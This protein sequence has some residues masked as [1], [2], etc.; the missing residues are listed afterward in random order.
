[1]TQAIL[2]TGGWSEVKVVRRTK[3]SVMCLYEVI[4]SEYNLGLFSREM[5][6]AHHHNLLNL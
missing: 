3:V 2:G 4:Q 1:M 5:D 6:I